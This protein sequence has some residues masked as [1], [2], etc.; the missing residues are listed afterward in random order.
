MN[1]R[2]LDLNLLVVLDALLTE[3]SVTRTGER[4]HLSQSATSNALSRLREYLDDELLVQVGNKMVLTSRAESLAEPVRNLLLRTEA[5]LRPE[6]EFCPETSGRMFRLLMSD[7]AALVV[8]QDGLPRLKS[9]APDVGV[10]VLPL[11]DIATQTLE[12]GEVDFLIGPRQLMSPDHPCE[13]LYTDRWVCIA[14]ADNPQVRGPLTPEQYLSMRHAGIRIGLQRTAP[15]DEDFLQSQGH[16]RRFDLIM[17]SF[18]LLPQLIVGTNLLGTV[19]ERIARH[20]AR[21]L[22][23]RVLPAPIE[24]PP[25]VAT[26]QWHQ[27]HGVDR[28][29]RWFR[30]TLKEIVK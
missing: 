26:I 21:I 4:I 10:E 24:I 17:S 7:Y 11:T 19:H 29:S 14:W 28:G 6:A 3:K 25:M 2:G 13:D 30:K 27:I 12:R 18:T 20:F 1:F 16:H 9:C 5:V 22:P 8:M 15:L 23:L